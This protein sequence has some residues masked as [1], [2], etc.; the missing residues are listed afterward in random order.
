[1]VNKKRTDIFKYTNS[2]TQP[3]LVHHASLEYMHI[4][5]NCSID[6]NIYISI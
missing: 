6:L 1:M 5:S 2:D 3:L 4:E